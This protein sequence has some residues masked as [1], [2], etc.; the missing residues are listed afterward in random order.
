MNVLVNQWGERVQIY[1]PYINEEE[2]S[3]NVSIFVPESSHNSGLYDWEPI[4][5][6]NASASAG[7]FSQ[8][9]KD[10]KFWW[11]MNPEV[12]RETKSYAQ[13]ELPSVYSSPRSR[14]QAK[15]YVM[16]PYR[17]LTDIYGQ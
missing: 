13:E 4:D 7:R 16:A 5:H 17:K 14:F 6:I 11:D 10:V 2:T 1:R 15:P 12:E 3:R 8:S 9:V